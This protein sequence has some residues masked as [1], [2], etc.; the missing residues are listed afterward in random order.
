M[1]TQTTDQ[2]LA[3]I[4]ELEAQLDAAHTDRAY[5]CLT[6]AGLER[7][8]ASIDTDSAVIFLDL[9]GMHSA[10]E[11]YGY[12]EVDSKIAASLNV[13]RSGDCTTGRWYS[14]DEIVLIVPARSAYRIAHRLADAFV[15]N[16]LSAT[17]GI[18]SLSGNL[19][20][21]VKSASDKVQVSKAANLRG[22]IV[23]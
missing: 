19:S 15:S 1:T 20:D 10:N 2:L 8:A 11:Q 22:I 5:G 21:S 17:F 7:R 6:R 16:G 14:G 23:S 9:D 13:V 4:A 18:S 3:R 12:S